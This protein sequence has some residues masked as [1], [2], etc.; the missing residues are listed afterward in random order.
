MGILAWVYSWFIYKPD[1]KV[2]DSKVY[3]NA[4]KELEEKLIEAETVRKEI[5]EKLQEAEIV[6]K[7]M[8][9]KLKAEEKN[10]KKKWKRKKKRK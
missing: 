7:E 1:L 6:R 4:I 10:L 9:E 2:K 8:E 3:E 5:E